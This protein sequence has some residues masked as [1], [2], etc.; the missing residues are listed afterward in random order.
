MSTSK[1][2]EHFI[3]CLFFEKSRL[4]QEIF[5]TL[6]TSL[7]FSPPLRMEDCGVHV[8]KYVDHMV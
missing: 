3:T 8:L 1:G 2:A 7:L 6:T 5:V 4:C